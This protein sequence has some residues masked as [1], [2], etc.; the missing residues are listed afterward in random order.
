MIMRVCHF[1]QRPYL[2]ESEKSVGRVWERSFFQ[3][4]KVPKA[5]STKLLMEQEP[6]FLVLVLMTGCFFFLSFKIFLA[7]IFPF[8]SFRFTQGM[9]VYLL[10]ITLKGYYSN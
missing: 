9:V 1:E 2:P 10:L 3:N 4:D 7:Y 8:L 6:K 5:P